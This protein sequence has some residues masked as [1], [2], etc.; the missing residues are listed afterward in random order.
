MDGNLMIVGIVG[1]FILA[2][3]SLGIL[4]Q[5]KKWI[6][7][8]SAFLQLFNLITTIQAPSVSIIKEW[9]FFFFVHP[10]YCHGL[11]QPIYFN[12]IVS[13]C[14]TSLASIPSTLKICLLASSLISLCYYPLS[15]I[16]FKHVLSF[17]ADGDKANYNILF[18]Y[19]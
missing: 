7:V 3:G 9:K 17:A 5:Q 18:C 13:A 2:I 15:V 19:N 10:S 14:S 1:F 6:N 4:I 11:K 16:Y 12:V 8:E